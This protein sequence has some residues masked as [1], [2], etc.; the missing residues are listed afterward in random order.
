VLSCSTKVLFPEGY[1]K[2]V[3]NVKEATLTK[4]A[5]YVPPLLEQ[6]NDLLRLDAKL[7]IA[8]LLSILTPK[9]RKIV[10]MRNGIGEYNG[11]MHT[12]EEVGQEFGITRE[13]VRQIEAKINVKLNYY[14]NE[15]GY[16]K[17]HRE[18]YKQVQELAR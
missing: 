5:E 7:T 6:T 3:D 15:Q 10:E 16:T 8:K 12:Y 4:I 1:A 9:E 2:I 14:Y 18:I 13:R 17:K 11:V